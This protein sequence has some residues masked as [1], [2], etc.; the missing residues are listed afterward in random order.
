ML[1]ALDEEVNPPP[2]FSSVFPEYIIAILGSPPVLSTENRKAY[3]QL[4]VELA[5]ELKPRNTVE[6]LLLCDL[7]DVSWGIVRLQRATAN[8]LNIS[9]KEALAGIFIDV[10]PGYRRSLTIEGTQAQL[11]QFHQ[12]EKW[13]DDWFE[14]PEQRQRVKAELSKYGLELAAITA[15]AFIARGAELERLDRMLMNAVLKR[16][17][18]MRTFTEHR[19]MSELRQPLVIDSE[20]VPRL[21]EA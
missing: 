3:E 19:A 7:A 14:G 12:A 16:T 20:Q 21:A 4:A 11:K 17:A 1:R 2:S 9:T 8:I 10:L 15:Q 18:I 5:L 6:W 13:A